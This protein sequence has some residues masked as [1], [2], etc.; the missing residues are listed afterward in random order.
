MIPKIKNKTSLQLMKDFSYNDLK[1]SDNKIKKFKLK[2]P[3]KESNIKDKDIFKTKNNLFFK[4]SAKD[5]REN[6]LNNNKFSPINNNS[7]FISPKNAKYK[8]KVPNITENNNKNN[9][10]SSANKRLYDE[11]ISLIIK[12]KILYYMKIK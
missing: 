7:L 9:I 11:E 1:D 12:K 5:L 2:S 4:E 10:P 8:L 6:T 3:F